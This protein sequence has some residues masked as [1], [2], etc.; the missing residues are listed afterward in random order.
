MHLLTVWSGRLH[1]VPAV[2]K[3]RLAATVR[4]DIKGMAAKNSCR[5]PRS[6]AQ[7]A[8]CDGA[9]GTAAQVAAAD[10]SA[11]PDTASAVLGAHLKALALC[12]RVPRPA[13]GGEFLQQDSHSRTDRT[14]A[15]FRGATP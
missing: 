6:T 9:V 5:M 1:R 14:R 4:T 13:F 15:D 10:A 3:A 7:G 2:L 11:E 8:L 12:G